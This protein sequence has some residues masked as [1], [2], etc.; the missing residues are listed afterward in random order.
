M[1]SIGMCRGKEPPF[2]PGLLLAVVLFRLC[3]ATFNYPMDFN[4]D[5]ID[6]WVICLKARWAILVFLLGQKITFRFAV[7]VEKCLLIFSLYERK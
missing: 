5:D 6:C 4:E 3:N 2:L 7:E 1:F